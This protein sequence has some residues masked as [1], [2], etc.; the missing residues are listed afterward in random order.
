MI[1]G[2]QDTTK[3]AV[4]EVVSTS[5]NALLQKLDATQQDLLRQSN[6]SHTIL[7]GVA[8]AQS[9]MV[10]KM[11][12]AND[13]VDRRMMEV[14]FSLDKKMTALGETVTSSYA[15]SSESVLTTLKDQLSVLGDQSNA[16]V[17]SAERSA[18]IID[19]RMGEVRR[20]SIMIMDLLTNAS[21]GPLAYQATGLDSDAIMGLR[22][23][24][25]E[26]LSKAGL[27]DGGEFRSAVV[28]MM[29]QLE[30][31][32]SQSEIQNGSNETELV[33]QELALIE[34]RLARQQAD[35]AG[36]V[37]EVKDAQLGL[38]AQVADFASRM[39]SN[40]E[41]VLA[42][43][44]PAVRDSPSRRTSNRGKEERG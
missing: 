38:Q 1:G 12:A 28:S 23:V 14:E 22:G 10:T 16:V 25:A 5:S 26:E 2:A 37:R 42:A 8:S 36:E 17:A 34:E 44:T 24:V 27:E 31:N 19:E 7:Q 43:P 3:K 39:E 13:K 21:D 33:K 18:A 4:A 9:S 15:I 20:Q 40:I 30:T 32:A 35:V 29:Q 11:E 6:E 41:R